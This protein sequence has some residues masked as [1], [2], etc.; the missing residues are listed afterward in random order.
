MTSGIYAPPSQGYQS[1]EVSVPVKD[2]LGKAKAE[3]VL[4]FEWC[5]QLQDNDLCHSCWQDGAW[6]LVLVGQLQIPVVARDIM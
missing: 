5:T 4:N 3:W 2:A 6:P 1:P